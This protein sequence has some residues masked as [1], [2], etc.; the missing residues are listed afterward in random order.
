MDRIT[1]AK[2][3]TLRSCP[4]TQKF[5][6]TWLQVRWHS[7]YEHYLTLGF[8]LVWMDNVLRDKSFLSS[9]VEIDF[10]HRS[11]YQLHVRDLAAND[12]A[13]LRNQKFWGILIATPRTSLQLTHYKCK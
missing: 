12:L 7:R 8:M 1:E 3:S 10:K 2:A 11:F 5:C 6:S 13:S 4:R 9:G